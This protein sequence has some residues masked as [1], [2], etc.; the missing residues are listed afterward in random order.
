M[1]VKD[2]M[3]AGVTWVGPD[4]S[5]NE[6][7][8]RMRDEDIG[9]IPIGENDR[10]IGMVTDRDICCRGVGNSRDI[11]LLTAR[12]VM[13]KP[14]LY[15]EADQDVQTAVRA[16]RKAKVRRLPVIDKNRRMVGMLGLGDIAAKASRETSATALKALA[17]HHR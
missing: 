14:I 12:D 1:Q 8:R 2:A 7:A 17:A 5:L 13:S 4:A 6:L 16:M 11:S 9:A 3:H 15:C 10:L